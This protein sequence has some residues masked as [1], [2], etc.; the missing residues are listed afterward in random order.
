MDGFSP[1]AE[2]IVKLVPSCNKLDYTPRHW[3][4]D[5]YLISTEPALIQVDEVN[6]ALSTDAMWWAKSLP[7]DLLKKALHN[8]LSFGLY[9]LPQPDSSGSN[10]N[11]TKQVGL[12]RVITDDVTFA[13]LSDVY[14]LPEHQGKGLGRWLLE[15]LDEVIKDWPHLRRFM[16]LTTD[17]MDFYR[18][19]LGAKE[20]SEFKTGATKIGMVEGPGAPSH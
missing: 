3:H 4:R 15:C 19:T 8:S 6:A 13:Y 16:F 9:A 14:I 5:N 11:G 7:R 20:W 12:A 17:A 18:K 10:S 1:T 2:G